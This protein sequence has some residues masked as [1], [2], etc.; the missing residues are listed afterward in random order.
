MVTYIYI[1]YVI[2][3]PDSSR[4][5][6]HKVSITVETLI[7]TIQ[8]EVIWESDVFHTNTFRIRDELVEVK[9]NLEKLVDVLGQIQP[10]IENMA[11]VITENALKS[12]ANMDIEITRMEKKA[13]VKEIIEETRDAVQKINEFLQQL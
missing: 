4:F 9:K 3:K 12:M 1:E 13:T 5:F 7:Y 8:R 2:D 6:E 10:S 11:V